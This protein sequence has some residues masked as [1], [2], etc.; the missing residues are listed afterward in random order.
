M[1]KIE[2]VIMQERLGPVKAVM[3]TLQGIKNSRGAPAI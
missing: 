3:L 1:K 2:A